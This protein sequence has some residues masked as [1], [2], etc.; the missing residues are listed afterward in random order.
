MREAVRALRDAIPGA[1][2][3]TAAERVADFVFWVTRISTG[4]KT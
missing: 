1:E 3:R 2:R 4:V